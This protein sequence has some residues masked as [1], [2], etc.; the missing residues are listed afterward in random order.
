[1]TLKRNIFCLVLIFIIG[2]SLF[3]N[4]YADEYA[5][6]TV[7]NYSPPSLLLTF[8]NIGWNFLNSFTYN[9]GEN[10]IRAGIGTWALIEAGVDWKWRSIVYDNTWISDI[11][12]PGLYIGYGM[13]ALVPIVTYTVGRI[14]RDEKLQIAAMALVQTLALTMVIQSPLKMITGRAKPDLVTELDHTRQEH[15]TDI[16]KDFNW[17]NFNA[18]A[19][20]PSGHTANAFS[21]AAAISEIYHDNL[22]LKIGVFTYAAC[23]G[24]GV[25]LDVHW[26]SEAFAGALIGYAIGKTV[27]RSF[28][29][30]LEKSEDDNRLS[31]YFTPDSVGVIVRY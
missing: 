16:S 22:W 20:W 5:E 26:A 8:H 13:P 2:F 6:E 28:R 19:G 3:A 4:D 14:I 9:N 25:T 1:M 23:I 31:F 18:Q 30:L 24:I 7:V 27:G 12:R 11:G 10:F 21:A 17:F 29:K 15:L